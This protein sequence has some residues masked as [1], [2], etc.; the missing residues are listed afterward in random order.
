MK[1]IILILSIF[2]CMNTVRAE[3]I[4]VTLDKCVDG[5]TAYFIRDNES[6]KYRFLSIDTPESTKEIEPFGKEASEFTCNILSNSS[7]IEI[8]YDPKSSRQDKYGR[9]LVWV[10]T[11]GELLQDKIISEGLAEVKYEKDNF[12]YVDKLRITEA[13]AKFKNIGMWKS[14]NNIYFYLVIII[15]IIL[16]VGNRKYRNKVHKKISGKVKKRIKKEFKL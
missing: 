9:E 10:F 3:K 16:Y 11:D 1:K 15:I 8:E 6:L 4:E 5:D 2:L 12:L 13:Q 7:L 14:E